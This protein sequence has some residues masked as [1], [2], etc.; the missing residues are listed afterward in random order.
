MEVSYFDHEDGYEELQRA[1]AMLNYRTVNISIFGLYTGQSMVTSI[2]FVVVIARVSWW[3]GLLIITAALPSLW[4]KIRNSKQGYIHDYNTL[5]PTRRR[6]SYFERTMTDKEFSKEVRLFGLGGHLLHSWQKYQKIWL[7]ETLQDSRRE[8]KA[9]LVSDGILQAA[10]AIAAIIFAVMIANGNLN[11]GEYVMLLQMI[12]QLQGSIESIMKMLRN[13]YQDGLFAENLFRFL[14]RPIQSVAQGTIKF[15]NPLRLGITFEDVWFRY[16]H[17]NEWVL[18]GVSF[19][20]VPGQTASLVGRNG[21]GKTTLVKLMMGMYRPNRGR[22]LLDGIP[23]QELHEDD[24]WRHM[25]VIFQ[26]FTR[27]E[28]TLR[29]SIGFGDISKLDNLDDIRH[30]SMRAGVSDIATWLKDGYETLLNQE[31]GG[32]NLSGGQWQKV[33]LARTL[34]RDADILIL[35][36]PTSAL[37]P[38]AEY[39]V[40]EQFKQLSGGRTTFL[41]SHRVGTARLAD[42]ILV[43]RDGELAEM[44]LHDDLVTAR[45]EYTSLFEAQAQWYRETVT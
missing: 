6:L 41:I 32:I 40:F 7:R 29:E 33:A 5:T 25:T 10:F 21:S 26:D 8:A 24:L 28:L 36:E 19:H 31:F 1:N 11:L 3:L 2:G 23:L 14:E 44:G 20:I 43:L 22:I 13:L 38:R 12:R 37:D 27:F 9:T 30:A 15:P 39:A 4:W 17:S 18:R 35:D 34:M 16:P 45:G 42:V